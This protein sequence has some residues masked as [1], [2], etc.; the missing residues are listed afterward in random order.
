MLCVCVCVCVCACVDLLAPILHLVEGAATQF[1]ASTDTFLTEAPTVTWG[2]R[3]CAGP[4]TV[5]MLDPDAPERSEDPA[6]A[7]PGRWGP[8]LHG[9]WTDCYREPQQTSQCKVRWLRRRALAVL[10]HAVCRPISY[11]AFPLCTFASCGRR[12]WAIGRHILQRATIATSFYC[13]SRRAAEQ[14]RLRKS[15]S[16]ASCGMYKVGSALHS[17]RSK[18]VSLR[19]CRPHTY[20]SRVHVASLEPLRI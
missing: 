5:L 16:T 13:T 17:A 14:S 8:W 12:R 20:A 3:L 1:N 19:F 9:L 11:P 6:G 2:K 7:T 18:A 4:C 10:C 15:R